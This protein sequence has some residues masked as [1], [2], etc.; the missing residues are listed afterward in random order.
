MTE[1]LKKGLWGLLLCFF[2]LPA[3]ALQNQ[4]LNHPSP[5]LA[6]HGN[7]P[8]HWQDWNVQTLELAKKERKL[9]FISSG[10]FACHWCHV[11]QRESYQNTAIAKLLNT[12]FIPVKID[13]ELNPALDEHLVDFVRRTQGHAGWPLNVFLT[14]EGYPLAGITYVPAEHFRVL[15]DRLQKMWQ[16]EKTQVTGLARQAMEELAQQRQSGNPGD[17]LPAKELLQKFLESAMGMADEMAGGFGQQN[18]FPMTPQLSTLLEIQMREPDESLAHFLRLTLDYMAL[19]GLRDHLAGGFFRYTV[20]PD[21]QTPHYEKMLYTQ[22]LLA[23]LY[24]RAAEV[25]KEPAYAEVA[26]NTLIFAVGKMCNR[27]ACVA[28][29]SAVDGKGAE[30]AYYLWKEAELKQLLKGQLWDLAREYWQLQGFESKPEGVLPMQG[31]ALKALAQTRGRPVVEI[32]KQLEQARQL[33]LAA[34]SKRS[35]PVDDKYLAGWNGLMLFALSKAA[36]QLDAPEFLVPGERLRNYLV[37]QLWNGKQLY[38]AVHQGQPVG[39]ASLADYAY[40]AR[41][42]KQWAEISGN[43]N[44]GRLADELLIVA[45]RDFYTEKGWLSSSRAL[46]PGMPSVKAQ[47]DGAL[48][49]AAAMVMRLSLT[50]KNEQLHGKAQK[51]VSATWLAV[52]GNPFWYA[53]SVEA[54]LLSRSGT[55]PHFSPGRKPVMEKDR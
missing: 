25:F 39:Q 10:Y 7:D 8:V 6:M 33:L 16:A 29:F 55:S 48:P 18:R 32:R 46:L 43:K 50:S 13:R 38:R 17:Q 28:S 21:W 3:L 36:G 44:D 4:L 37:K 42:L 5:Y 52:Q 26:R 31:V 15:L 54:L 9:L 27:E 41:G 12:W 53:S 34:R 14:P 22:A 35:L 19:K 2:S 30:G 11:M 1:I 23:D 51:L 47:E 24:L 45:W 49:A 20:D 40:V